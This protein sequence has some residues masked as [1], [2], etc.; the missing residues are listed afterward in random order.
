MRP[1]PDTERKLAQQCAMRT[2]RRLERLFIRLEG[3]LDLSSEDPFQKEVERVLNGNTSTVIVDLREL[4]FIDSTGLRML[5][6][7]HREVGDGQVDFAIF[8]GDGPVRRV[9]EQTGLD[10]ILPLVDPPPSDGRA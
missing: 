3:E 5:I 8:C 9:F 2:E 4:T 10:A 1:L 6:R 7:L